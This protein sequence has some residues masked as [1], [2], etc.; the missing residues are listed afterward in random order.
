MALIPQPPCSD[1]NIY[2]GFSPLLPKPENHAR[3]LTWRV[4][5]N[6]FMRE[7]FCTSRIPNDWNERQVAEVIF[8]FL[9][10]SEEKPPGGVR[11]SL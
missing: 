6:I 8:K 4:E 10:Q 1:P 5:N 3:E 11:C 7:P 9:E 2:A